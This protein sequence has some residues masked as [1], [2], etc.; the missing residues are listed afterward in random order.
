[1]T[2]DED[3]LVELIAG[4]DVSQTE[5][6]ER[7]GVSRR[8]VWRIAN[9]HSRPD[10]QQKIADTVEGYRQAAIRLA[11]KFMKPLL[12]KQIEVALEGDGE[13]SRRC[14]EF[15][16]KTFMIVL[17]EQAAKAAT[18]RKPRRAPDEQHGPVA[19]GMDLME[20]PPDLKDQVVKELGGPTGELK[21]VIGNQSHGT[22]KPLGEDASVISEPFDVAQGRRPRITDND[23]EDIRPTTEHDAP[24]KPVSDPE[25]NGGKEGK[26]IPDPFDTWVTLPAGKKVYAET[27]R[28]IEEAKAEAA[29][30]PTRRRVPRE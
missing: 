22:T 2:Y 24:D 9:G 6:A 1:M 7:V 18:K 5:I 16:L 4:G 12:K 30:I 26:K 21:P 20:L 14:R 23:N 10:L 27:I 8:T 25:G 15:L 13:I 28:I 29:M 17:P 3:L 11:A 19:L